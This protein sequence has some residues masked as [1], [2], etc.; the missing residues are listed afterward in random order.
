MMSNLRL[1]SQRK[2][3]PSMLNLKVIQA[4]IT[5]LAQR[6]VEEG[7]HSSSLPTWMGLSGISA[8]V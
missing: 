8:K 5:S 2:A 1:R 4:Q 7:K 3:L 6:D